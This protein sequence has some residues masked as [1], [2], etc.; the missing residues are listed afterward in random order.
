MHI[1]S[2]TVKYSNT[3]HPRI[4]SSICRAKTWELNYP[5]ISFMLSR[6]YYADHT[7]V[8]DTMGLSTMYHST[9]DNLVSCSQLFLHY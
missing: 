6:G 7:S 5:A 3:G 2:T 8:M 1:T 9:W 4:V